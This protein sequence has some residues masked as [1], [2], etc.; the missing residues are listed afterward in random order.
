VPRLA[1]AVLTVAAATVLGGAARASDS[2]SDPTVRVWTISYRA[3]NGWLRRAY[4]LVPARYGRQRPA[5]LPLVI[6]PHG[7]GQTGS[8]NAGIWRD[9]PA[10]GDFAV[11]S[12]DGHGRRLARYSWGYAGQIRD[13][14]RMPRLVEQALPWLKVD[15][16]Q[17]YAFGGSMGGQEALLLAARYPRLVAGAATFD[18]VTDLALQYRAFPRVPCGWRCRRVWQPSLGHALQQLARHEVGGTP[19]QVPRSYATRSPMAHATALALSCVPL[20]LW[21]SNADRTIDQQVHSRRLFWEIKRL[22]P[23]APVHGFVGWWIHTTAMRAGARLPLALATFGLL[24]WPE[25]PLGSL[26]VIEPDESQFDCAGDD[27]PGF[28]SERPVPSR[29]PG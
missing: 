13:L 11:V 12:P 26:W 1:L 19:Q 15:R 17:V 10:Q 21:W 5:T 9:L 6:S 3:H 25:R 2:P 29:G 7:R 28:P 20:Q 23:S 22:N 4:V 18:A 8:S 27:D 24:K 16:E 14:A